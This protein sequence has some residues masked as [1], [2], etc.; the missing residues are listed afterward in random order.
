M[1]MLLLK[2]RNIATKTVV[3]LLL[4][5]LFTHCTFSHYAKKSYAR[6]AKEKPYDVIIVPGV[7]YEGKETTSI[8]KMRLY[9]AKYLFD[10]GF[11]RNIIFSG[12]SVYSPYVESI[13]M[14]IMADSLGIPAS[15]TFSETKAEHSTENVYYSWKMAKEMGFTEIALASDPF[16]SRML[17]SFIR[18][19][20]PG[21]KVVP[22]VLEEMDIEDKTLP[23]INSEPAYVDNFVSIKER[24]S[25]F[26]RFRGTLG[27][28][29]KDEVNA[30]KN[31]GSALMTKGNTNQ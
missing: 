5:G 7:P 12:S 2:I 13:A 4:G 24:E 11:T 3:V 28:R 1:K 14:K 10:S 22:V 30:N 31:K 26:E 23:E 6:A 18:R 9:W 17:K 19:Y 27:K 21:L 16:Q 15:R 29:V 8:M 25:F 20:C